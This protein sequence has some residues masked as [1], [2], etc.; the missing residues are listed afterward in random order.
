ML[1]SMFPEWYDHD[2]D[3]LAQIVRTGTIALDTNVLLKLY[4]I[5]STARDD[6]LKMLAEGSV[7]PRLFVPYQVGLEYQ[8]NRVDVAREQ[9]SG[10]NTLRREIS[11]LKDAVPDLKINDDAS[12]IRDAAVRDEI[13]TTIDNATKKLSARFD[14][15]WEKIEAIRDTHVIRD[16][17]IRRDDPV[18]KMLEKLLTDQGQVGIKP[19]ESTLAERKKKAAERYKAKVPPGYED[20]SGKD[21]KEDP[22]GDYLIWRE[23]LDRAA[24]KTGPILFVTDDKKADW[25]QLDK[26]KRVLGPRSELRVE[27]AAET[28]HPYHQ[29]TLE[30]FLRLARKHLHL[31]VNDDTVQQ[32]KTTSARNLFLSDNELAATNLW[33]LLQFPGALTTLSDLQEDTRFADKANQRRQLLRIVDHE[34]KSTKDPRVRRRL[35]QLGEDIG[36]GHGAVEELLNEARS[37]AARETYD[38]VR[39]GLTEEPQPDSPTDG[40]S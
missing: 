6:V 30:G 8:R 32:V 39:D 18:R 11:K 19:D 22:S 27:M 5:S 40:E 3:A 1:Q 37:T 36:H 2:G 38:A 13:N 21:P 31:T 35:Q 24:L 9:S 15:L 29:T 26:Q 34:L 17:D 28:E 7:R 20:A 25:Y 10:Y 12:G 23:L 33:Q 14:E 4:R 16:E